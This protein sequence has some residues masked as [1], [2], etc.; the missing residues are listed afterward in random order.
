M[1][2]IY[3]KPTMVPKK[4]NKLTLAATYD[5]TWRNVKESNYL[6]VSYKA[7]T[8]DAWIWYWPSAC[9]FWINPPSWQPS[10]TSTSDSECGV[11]YG[12]TGAKED[13]IL[14]P[15]GVPVSISKISLAWATTIVIVLIKD[16]STAWY[17]AHL[18][19]CNQRFLASKICSSPTILLWIKAPVL[20]RRPLQIMP[21]ATGRERSQ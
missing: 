14:S 3:I 9:N 16:F 5:E 2:L 10:K 17:F 12:I 4:I 19:N 15:A 20:L 6:K 18:H 13:N 11:A 1:K 7:Y 8:N 21:L